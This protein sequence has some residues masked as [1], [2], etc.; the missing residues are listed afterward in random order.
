MYNKCILTRPPP[1]CMSPGTVPRLSFLNLLCTFHFM[2]SGKCFTL[3]IC[4]AV[5]KLVCMLSGVSSNIRKFFST[6]SQFVGNLIYSSR[7]SIASMLIANLTF[8]NFFHNSIRSSSTKI[9]LE[10]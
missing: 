6:V 1:I 3:N 4:I 5:A 2:N 8:L 7:F 10:L 9:P